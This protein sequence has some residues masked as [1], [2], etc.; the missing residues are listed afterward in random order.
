MPLVSWKTTWCS[1]PKDNIFNCH[2]CKNLKSRENLHSAAVLITT[3]IYP[4]ISSK[5]FPLYLQLVI[6]EFQILLHLYVV[7]IVTCCLG[8]ETNN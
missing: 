1:I 6:L 5:V 8:N 4:N 2:H 3:L 7:H